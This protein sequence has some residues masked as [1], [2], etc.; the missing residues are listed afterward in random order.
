[1][2]FWQVDA[3]TNR[4]FTGNPAAVFVLKED[5]SDDLKQKIAMEMNLSETVFVLLSESDME[6]RWFTPNAEVNLCGHATLAAAHILWTKGIT[7]SK[8][9]QFQ[10]RSGMLTVEK[11]SEM[12]TLDFPRQDARARPELAEIA[13]AIMAVHPHFVG[14]NGEDCLAVLDTEDALRKLTPDFSLI[15]TLPER[16]L[17]VTA[18]SQIAP[19]DYI[20]RGFFPKLG[21]PEDPVTGSANTALAPYWATTL[22]KSRLTAFQASARGGEVIVEVEGDRVLISGR[23]CTVTEGQLLTS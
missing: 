11:E 10:S 21:V 13:K 1:M 19:Y 23:A 17:V 6:I 8:T 12:Y 4:P 18:R 15:Q 7:N 20:Y 3:F 2:Q 5:I 9:L 16:G 14:S 22:G